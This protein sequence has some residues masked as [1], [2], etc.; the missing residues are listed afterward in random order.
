M[1]NAILFVAAVVMTLATQTAFA[2]Q[3]VE[4]LESPDA[5]EAVDDRLRA[6]LNARGMTLVQVVHH[7][8]NARGVGESL[9]ET[10]TFIFGNPQVGTPMMQCQGQ[11][12]L[13][14]P[15][16]MVIREDEGRTLVEWNDPLYLA[17]RHGLEGCDL[18]LDKV[19][20]ALNGIAAEAA[21]Q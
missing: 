18:P 21:G 20:E 19:V 14:L 9:P 5:I 16:K 2:G 13:D 15:Q 4:R 10:R 12:A 8:E 17:E 11:V 6:A 7:A 1:K 3:G